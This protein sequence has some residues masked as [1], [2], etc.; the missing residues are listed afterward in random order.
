MYY[1]HTK[2]ANTNFDKNQVW[3]HV[4]KVRQEVECSIPSQTVG[5]VLSP[6]QLGAASFGQV[7]NAEFQMSK[8]K[9][10]IDIKM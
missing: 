3:H 9:L 7:R 1:V 5:S 4:R 10:H 2:F 6:F 8:F